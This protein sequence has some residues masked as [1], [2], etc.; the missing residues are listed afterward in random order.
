MTPITSVIV[1]NN[2]VRSPLN[3]PAA[4]S[5]AY[6]TDDTGSAMIVNANATK[7][8]ARVARDNAVDRTRG[9]TCRGLRGRGPQAQPVPL[10][11][12]LAG[13]LCHTAS[14]PAW[15]ART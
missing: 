10:Y 14:A 5:M 1:R 9:L 8:P 15:P 12:G 2:E 3:A 13:V 11:S 6:A 4:A 7:R